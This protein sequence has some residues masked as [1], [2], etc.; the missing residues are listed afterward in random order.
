MNMSTSYSRTVAVTVYYS[1]TCRGVIGSQI[2]NRKI[3]SH[4]VNASLTTHL[5]KNTQFPYYQFPQ[6]VV[7][8]NFIS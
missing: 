8:L 5:Q 2:V 1:E 3:G 7:F 6:I 4:F